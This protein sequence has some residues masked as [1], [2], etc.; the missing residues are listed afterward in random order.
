ME[1][2]NG[3]AVIHFDHSSSGL[4]LKDSSN[5]HFQIAGSD[6][7]FHPAQVELKTGHIVL[8]HPD[9]PQPAAVRYLWD[10]TS[11]ATLFNREGL[12]ASSFRTDDWE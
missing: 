1:I 5:H 10:N 3:R 6:R 9:I 8:W 11:A 12:P 7:I 2:Q 4:I